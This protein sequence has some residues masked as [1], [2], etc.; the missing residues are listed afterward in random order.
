MSYTP[1]FKQEPTFEG[2]F[3]VADS[4]FAIKSMEMSLS[5][6][7][8]VNL[9]QAFYLRQDFDLIDDSLWMITAE[10]VVIDFNI[11]EKTMGFFVRKNTHFTDFNISKE[12]P[13]TIFSTLNTRMSVLLDGAEDLSSLEWDSIR[14]VK[15]SENEKGVYEMVDSIKNVPIFITYVDVIKTIFSGFYQFGKIELGDYTSVY[16]YNDTEGSRFKL[17]ARSSTDFS[18]KLYLDGYLAYGVRDDRYKYG[19]GARYYFRKDL[20]RSLGFEYKNDLEQLGISPYSL[21]SDNFLNAIFS[22]TGAANKL[23]NI[24]KIDIFY[25]HEWFLGFENTLSLKYKIMSPHENQGLNF[26]PIDSPDSENEIIV[27]EVS[28]KT[29]IAFNEHT[30]MGR[31]DKVF[32]ASKYPVVNINYTVAP[33]GAINST[34]NFHRL[35][36]GWLHS[37]KFNP[38]GYFR[39]YAEAGKIFG[40]VPYPLL[41]M[42]KGNETY[43]YD[44]YAFNLMNYYEFI[45]D[46]WYSLLLEHHF[47]GFFLHKIPLC[48]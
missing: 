47:E 19:L 33:K 37:M 20:I 30:V 32:L 15:L 42:H 26:R 40:T 45:S 13:D 12:I 29:R 24:E 7:V 14:P 46:E 41:E 6:H 39:Y 27:S 28:L 21:P 10:K 25:R 9:I 5:K 38:F 1:K 35:Q 8:N 34:Y 36:V 11:A 31:E 43:W 22:R 3:W 16:S 4:S 44:S 18:E 48:I 2:Y 23:T 17:M